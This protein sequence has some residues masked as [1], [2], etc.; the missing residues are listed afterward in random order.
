MADIKIS[1]NNLLSM[2][3]E[4]SQVLFPKEP[5]PKV[6]EEEL[7]KSAFQNRNNQI[8][9]YAKHLI[10]ADEF[11]IPLPPD[12]AT[13]DEI[14]NFVKNCD[15]NQFEIWLYSIAICIKQYISEIKKID[16]AKKIINDKN[17][18]TKNYVIGKKMI[19]GV[20]IFFLL[21][22]MIVP[23]VWAL[24]QWFIEREWKF[25]SLVGILDGLFG[26]IALVS[27]RILDRKKSNIEATADRDIGDL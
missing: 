27:E 26:V 5:A 3:T 21:S 24:V 4:I 13:V 10:D 2:L 12:S 11:Y 8:I 25:D 14:K 20:A 6:D 18:K 9:G 22:T 1:K 7:K 15:A 19:F 16:G 23:V 17:N